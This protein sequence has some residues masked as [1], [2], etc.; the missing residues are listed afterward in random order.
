MSMLTFMLW[1]TIMNITAIILLVV[2]LIL[3]RV[4]IIQI[5]VLQSDVN[6][7]R[8]HITKLEYKSIQE[9]E[10]ESSTKFRTNA[11]D[12]SKL[13]DLRSS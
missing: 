6:D 5:N 12:T 9:Q 2:L 1:T 7:L 11:G 3:S 13:H 8:T 4:I 10:T